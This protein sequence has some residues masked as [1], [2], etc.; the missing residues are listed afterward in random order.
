[1]F[2]VHDEDKG[3]AVYRRRSRFVP[4]SRFGGSDV[5]DVQNLLGRAVLLEHELQS[6]Q[7]VHRAP[8]S[9][10]SHDVCAH[11]AHGGTE[12]RAMWLRCH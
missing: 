11:E 2:V 4:A 7:I 6:T 9:I 8:V 10:D 3:A 12:G 5:L 1:M